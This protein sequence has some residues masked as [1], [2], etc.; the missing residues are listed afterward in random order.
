MRGVIEASTL[1]EAARLGQFRTIVAFEGGQPVRRVQALEPLVRY[2]LVVAGAG[3]AWLPAFLCQPDVVRGTLMELMPEESRGP[4]DI[5]ALYTA[6]AS[7][8]PKVR[9]FVR[10]LTRIMGPLSL[11]AG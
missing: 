3:A 4:I 7:T 11:P 6:Q 8:T 9:A 2:G 10:F 1:A 5:H